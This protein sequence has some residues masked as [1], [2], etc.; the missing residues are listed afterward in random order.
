MAGREVRRSPAT[1]LVT[2]VH[3]RCHEQREDNEDVYCELAVESV[4]KAVAAAGAAV[5]DIPERREQFIHGRLAS[6]ACQALARLRLHG[7]C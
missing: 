4:T 6:S 1:D 7:W 5:T 2:N 3:S